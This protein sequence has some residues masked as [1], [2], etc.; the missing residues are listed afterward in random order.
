MKYNPANMRF[1]TLKNQGAKM[2]PVETKLFPRVLKKP[3]TLFQYF[4]RRFLQQPC[5]ARRT[6]QVRWTSCPCWCDHVNT[7][8]VEV[9]GVLTDIWAEYKVYILYYRKLKPL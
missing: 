8:S 1:P 9:L 3:Y 5:T 6:K 2:V 4:G 7:S